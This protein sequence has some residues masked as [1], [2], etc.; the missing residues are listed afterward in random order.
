MVSK[1]W[2]GL[3]NLQSTGQFF[4]WW[5][6]NINSPKFKKP[7]HILVNPSWHDAFPGSSTNYLSHG[8]SDHCPAT[9]SLCVDSKIFSKQFQ[10]FNHLVDHPNLH[11]VVCLL[12]QPSSRG[13]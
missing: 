5:D 3:T 8:L 2:L 6:S 10:F 11:K 12:L 4:T 9:T 7:D 13:L 1:F